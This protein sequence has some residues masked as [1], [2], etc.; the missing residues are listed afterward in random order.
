MVQEYVSGHEYGVFYTRLPEES[1][2]RIFAITDKRLIAVTG[3]GKRTLEQLIL[4]DN[5]AVCMARFFL[6]R[7]AERLDWVPPAGDEVP[8]TRLGTHARGAL[9]LDGAHLAT[10]ALL[11]AVDQLGREYDGFCFGRYDLRAPSAEALASGGP[12]QVIELNGV[13][14]EATSIYDPRHGLFHAWRTLCAQWRLAFEIGAR[15]R[16]RGARPAT[17]RELLRLL[18]RHRRA[19]RAHVDVESLGSGDGHAGAANQVPVAA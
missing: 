14:S 19:T 11:N 9:F 5:R 12:F 8:L 4:A 1:R 10:P 16:V 7:H 18:R 15:N 2:G 3:D 13:S 17:V 6:A